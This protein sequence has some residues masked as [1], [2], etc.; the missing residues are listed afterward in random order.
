MVGSLVSWTRVALLTFNETLDYFIQRNGND[1]YSK[2]LFNEVKKNEL[3]LLKNPYLGI[4]VSETAYRKLIFD[5]YSL[6]YKF[7]DTEITIVLFWDNRR[8]PELLEKELISVM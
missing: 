3:R 4:E 7:I 1:N 6:F 5:D 8:S 2:K